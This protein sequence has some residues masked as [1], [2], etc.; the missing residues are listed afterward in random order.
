[1]PP[2]TSS[3]DDRRESAGSSSNTAK[4]LHT[5]GRQ[6][7]LEPRPATPRRV[8]CRSRRSL[9]L[10]CSPVSSRAIRPP[11]PASAPPSWAR[12]GRLRAAPS[13]AARASTHATYD[14]VTEAPPRRRR[15]THVQ[16]HAKVPTPGSKPRGPPT[17]TPTGQLGAA[18]A[19]AG[20]L[21]AP[22][23]CRAERT[24]GEQGG[25]DSGGGT[26]CIVR[27]RSPTC[28]PNR[29]APQHHCRR[30]RHRS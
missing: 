23:V 21:G 10:P 25:A 19:A 11:Q 1:M 8:G 20:A 30:R 15:L 12:A 13:A 17:G 7:S 3:S 5:V 14:F 16:R 26:V 24:R 28:A 2:G 18:P 6:T 27:R 29:R 9:P 22:G 4:M